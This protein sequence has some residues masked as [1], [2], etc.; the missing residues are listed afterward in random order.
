[1]FKKTNLFFTALCLV[2]LSVSF[3]KALGAEVEVKPGFYDQYVEY[4][5]QMPAPTPLNGGES[6]DLLE[7][8]PSYRM[9]FSIL[10]LETTGLKKT[11][12][13]AGEKINFSSN[14]SYKWKGATN[15]KKIQEVCLEK[16]KDEAQCKMPQ[17]Y[18]VSEF[19]NLGVFVQ[20]WRKD[21]TKEG[22]DKGDYLIDEFY[23]LTDE[24]LTENEEKNFPVNWT[25]P[26][27]LKGGSYYFLLYLN[28]N[29]SF[30]L[31]GTPLAV[32][33]ETKRVDF[34]VK[35]NGQNGLEIDKNNLK[36]GGL[37]YAYRRPAPTVKGNQVEVEIPLFN[38][39]ETDENAA[40]K[41]DLYSWGRTNSKDLIDSKTESQA[42]KANSSKV[43]KY[44]FI[45]GK[46]DSVYDLKIKITTEKSVTSAYVRFVMDGKHRGIFRF[47]S[48]VEEGKEQ[49]PMFCLR[50]ANW[51]GKFQGKIKLTMGEEK[52]QEEGSIN[53]DD[54]KC[55]ILKNLLKVKNNECQ[56]VKGEIFDKEGN[57]VD[58]KEA[59]V[60][61]GEKQVKQEKIKTQTENLKNSNNNLIYALILFMLLL[62]GGVVI[63]KTKK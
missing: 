38:M 6:K 14:L 34:E 3:Q 11:D 47:L 50:D 32:F 61:C 31:L 25:I 40:V 56:T 60:N 4:L 36:V 49:T 10:K 43:L 55:F 33:S 12:Y 57:L 27:E 37:E 63:L 15:I 23:A 58:S 28:Q 45:P 2:I 53:A 13:L 1:M 7:V 46:K 51:S 54:G 16:V 62:I 41:Y 8:I 18:K 17:A 35:N 59:S 24:S 5:N 29:K 22:Q 44:A 39:N 9:P 26:Q 20:V 42:L 48:F 30:D 21:Q 19:N 52:F